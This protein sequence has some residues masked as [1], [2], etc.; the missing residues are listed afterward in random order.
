MINFFRKIRK[1]LADDNKPIKYLRYA[2]GEILLVVIGI[3]IALSINNWNENQKL[4]KEEMI[5]LASL[6]DDLKEAKRQSK[7]SIEIEELAIDNLKGVLKNKLEREIFIKN[8]NQDSIFYTVLWDFEIEA[9]VINTYTDIKSSGKTGRIT[10]NEIRERFT[11]L[12][13]KITNLKSLINDRLTVHQIRIDDIVVNEINFLNLLSASQPNID[14][15]KEVENDYNKLLENEKVRNLLG[16]KTE[17]TIQGVYDKFPFLKKSSILQ[18]NHD[19][20]R[21]SI[22]SSREVLHSM[23]IRPCTTGEWLSL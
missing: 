17:L 4:K 3:L 18:R 7:K 23:G 20:Q 5:I 15:N 11:N 8:F 9:P 10:N 12:E 1:K 16:I 2:I 14:F 19:N 13:L 22:S 6:L 21:P